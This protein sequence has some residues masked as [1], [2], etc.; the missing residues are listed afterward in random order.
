ML[1]TYKGK[2]KTENDI[3]IYALILWNDKYYES[4]IYKNERHI[5]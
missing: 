3:L 2:K 5:K 1:I 4:T